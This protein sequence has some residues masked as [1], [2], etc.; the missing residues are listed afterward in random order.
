MNDGLAELDGRLQK[1]D[2]ILEINAV[3]L[4]NGTQEAAAEV[5]KV[6]DARSLFFEADA[7]VLL[8]LFFCLVI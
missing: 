8:L 2:R 1:D 4:R 7:L 3:D 5:I 6:W